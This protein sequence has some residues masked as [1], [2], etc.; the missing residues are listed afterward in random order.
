MGLLQ[1]FLNFKHFKDFVEKYITYVINDLNHFE[2]RFSNILNV[3]LLKRS[4]P[5]LVQLFRI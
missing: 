4:D 5:D 3:F 2:E 1:D